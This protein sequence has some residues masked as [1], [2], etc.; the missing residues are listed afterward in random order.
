MKIEVV[1]ASEKHL[2]YVTAINDAIDNAAKARGTGIARRTN[3]YIADKIRSGKAI[4]A[5][6]RAEFV[7]F[8]YIESWGHQK[9]VANSGLIVVP[10]Y[11]GLGVAKQIKK[12]AFDLSRRRFPEAK[13]FGLTTGEQVMRI[14]TSLGYVPVT[15]AKLTDDEEFWAGC[16]SCVNYDI[17]QR[18]NMTKCLCT[19][20]VYDPEAVARQQE[21]A[22][23]AG[24]SASSGLF[25]HVRHVVSSMLAVRGRATSRS[26]MKN[27]ANL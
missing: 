15:F 12:A 2:S 8:C 22:R 16:K 1:V 3:E 11:R 26:T 24:K 27:I 7:G 18:T 20:M 17:L 4:I 23:K 19:G 21:L 5:L 13:L 14:N 10:A 25:K 9:F 6:N